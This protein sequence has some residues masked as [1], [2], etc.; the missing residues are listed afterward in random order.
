MSLQNIIMHT[1]VSLLAHYPIVM[2]YGDKDIAQRWKSDNDLLPD[3]NKPLPEQT[4]AGN[5]R[6]SLQRNLIKKDS[7]INQK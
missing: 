7:R 3:D 1:L 6:Y 2:S 5:Y 4:V